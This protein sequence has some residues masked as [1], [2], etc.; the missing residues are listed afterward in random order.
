MH[1]HHVKTWGAGGG[2][3][4]NLV[5]LCALHHSQFH[6]MGRHTFANRYNVDLKG[7]AIVLAARWEREQGK[8]TAA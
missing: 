3:R 2:D 8:G 1:A 4:A 6:T 7:I 5:G